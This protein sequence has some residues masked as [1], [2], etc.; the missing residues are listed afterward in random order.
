MTDQQRDWDKEL[1]DID[2]A[3]A[4]QPGNPAAAPAGGTVATAPKRRF[5]ALVWVWT[6]LAILLAVALLVW[7]Y[8]KSCG[9]RLIFFLGAALLALIAGAVGAFT[10]WAHRQGMAMVLSLLVILFA[11]IMAAREIL[12]RAGYARESLEWTC[13]PALPAPSPA[14]QPS[15]Q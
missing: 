5:V 9:I 14:P 7:P 10:S 4:R 2:R 13:P 6:L 8:D 12:P 11:G 15:A 1:A 3:I